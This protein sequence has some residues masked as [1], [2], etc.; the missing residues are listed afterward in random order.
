L[1]GS[2]P[3]CDVESNCKHRWDCSFC[4]FYSQYQPEDKRFLSP[5]QIQ[6]KEERKQ[7]KKELK[8]TEASKRGKNNKR[9][10]YKSEVAM[11]KKY[12]KWGFEADRQPLSGALKGKYCSD[13]HVNILGKE[14]LHED[15][16]RQDFNHY[17]NLTDVNDYVIVR[18]FCVMLSE[19]NFHQLLL[20]MQPPEGLIIEDD[21]MKRLHDFFDQDHSDI[22]SCRGS[23][24]KKRVFC[25][26]IPFWNELKEACN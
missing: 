2:S 15:K 16:V 5:A 13:I 8:Q 24:K 26:T 7:A 12:R 22:V 20:G 1:L 17:Y 14:R 3:V 9:K 23:G 4:N 10:G 18:D 21:K 11:V 25:L 19:T 6:R